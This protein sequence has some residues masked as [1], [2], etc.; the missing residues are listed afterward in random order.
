[1]LHARNQI[2]VPETRYCDCDI[3]CDVTHVILRALKV[4]GVKILCFRSGRLRSTF[5]YMA[6]IHDQFDTILILDFGSQVS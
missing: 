6:D 4:L 2:L 5:T 3:L 1:M